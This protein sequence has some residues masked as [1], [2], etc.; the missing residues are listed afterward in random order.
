MMTSRNRTIQISAAERVALKK[1]LLKITATKKK[2][3]GVYNGDYLKLI[4]ALPEKS[5]DLLF[6]DPPYNL[7]KNF[8][9]AKFAKQD[10]HSYTSWLDETLAALKPFLRTTASIYICG[11]WYSSVSIYTAAAKHFVVR[12]R[13]CWEREKGRG[14][15]TNWKNSSEDIWFCTMSDSY[16]FNVDSV[17]LRRRVIAPYR[18]TD[19]T[20]KDWHETNNGQFR[21]SHPSNFW[22]DISVPFW[23]MAENTDH[24]TQ[25]SEK[26][27][28][29]LI[30]A[31]SN[32]GDLLFDPF[33]GS[34]S[35]L[36]VA[37]KL[38][39][40]YLGAE[41]NEE[42]C[43]LAEKRLLLAEQDKRIQGFAQGVFWERNTQ[44]EQDAASKTKLKK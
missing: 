30:L 20:P 26:L 6:L 43:L 33:A 37:K 38:K 3:C 36:V 40:D 32:P 25:K 11:D 4:K 9:G 29:K 24:P 12:N 8:H 19:G 5:I 16:T 15:K 28:A 31:S 34:G 7:N 27:M 23:S 18:L 13:I 14:A 39:R 42:Y 10:V 2:L 1:R 35:S 17:K 41:I 44:A 21:D 22:S